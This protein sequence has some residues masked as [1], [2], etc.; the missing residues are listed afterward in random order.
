M[1]ITNGAGSFSE[2]NMVVWGPIFGKQH[3]VFIVTREEVVIAKWAGE[4]LTQRSGLRNDKSERPPISPEAA[5]REQATSGEA[6]ACVE[7]LQAGKAVR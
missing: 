1:M 3:S 6:A 5:S 7:A 2:Q 4:S